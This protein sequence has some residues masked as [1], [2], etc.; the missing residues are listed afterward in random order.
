MVITKLDGVNY[1]NFHV[2][3]SITNLFKNYLFL[4]EVLE[5]RGY[6]F[7]EEDY[8]F[9][10]KKTLDYGNDTIRDLEKEIEKFN[11]TLK[12]LNEEPNS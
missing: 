7:G 4:F 10:R 6:V 1:L 2:S 8:K 11:I 5:Q 3:R 9:I 12:D